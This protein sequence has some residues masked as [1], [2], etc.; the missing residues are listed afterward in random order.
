M[1][2]A[3]LLE[4]FTMFH[5]RWE[6]IKTTS[7]ITREELNKLFLTTV[8]IIKTGRLLA[9]YWTKYS[10]MDEVKMSS[11]NYTWPFLK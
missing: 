5:Q 1:L 3:A 6:V 9:R 8:V 2:L 11:T 7:V 4:I 10:R